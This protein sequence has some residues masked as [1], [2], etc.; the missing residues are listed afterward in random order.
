[1]ARNGAEACRMTWSGSRFAALTRMVSQLP[2]PRG[3]LPL[4]AGL[5]AWQLLQTGNS[6]YFP[7]PSAWWNGLM[8]IAAGGK[9]LS[10]SIATT[11]TIVV[12]LGN[13]RRDR[14]IAAH[15]PDAWPAARILSRYAAAGDRAASD[16]VS[17]L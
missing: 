3:L 14:H 7:P 11:Q 8:Q 17:R 12:G 9:L 10:A 6:P 15:Q 13:R 5:V 16:F 4:I 1:M 2:S